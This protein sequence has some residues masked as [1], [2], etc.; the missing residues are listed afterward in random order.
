M[1]LFLFTE[2]IFSVLF[3][4]SFMKCKSAYPFEVRCLEVLFGTNILTAK[5]GGKILHRLRRIYIA[6]NRSNLIYNYRFQMADLS[7]P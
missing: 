6:E 7:D 1:M 2:S 3:L 4:H 5:R